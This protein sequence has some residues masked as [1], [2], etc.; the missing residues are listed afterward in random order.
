M[1][2]VGRS[3]STWNALRGIGGV[4][5]VVTSGCAHGPVWR[6]RVRARLLQPES[7]LCADGQPVKILVARECA[8]GVCGYT[9]QP[10]RWGER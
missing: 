4:L 10:G 5:L 2:R 1:R 6:D 8:H 9:C 7:M 3:G